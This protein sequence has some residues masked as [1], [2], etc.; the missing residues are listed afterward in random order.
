[1]KQQFVD[2]LKEKFWEP[3]CISMETLGDKKRELVDELTD[4]WENAFTTPQGSVCV[5]YALWY[6]ADPAV[7]AAIRAANYRALESF[8]RI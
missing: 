5:Q 4:F 6:F 8:L 1:M 2:D 3:G 7:K